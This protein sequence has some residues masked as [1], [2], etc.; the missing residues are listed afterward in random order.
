MEF[1]VCCI[2]YKFMIRLELVL[3]VLV[4]SLFKLKKNVVYDL[5]FGL[6][7]VELIVVLCESN[8]EH[9]IVEQLQ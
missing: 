5:K 6:Y 8:V 7:F 9:L 4:P 1:D 2:A 3:I